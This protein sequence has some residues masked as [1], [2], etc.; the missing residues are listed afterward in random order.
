MAAQALDDFDT[1]GHG[2]AEVPR[3]LHQVA[4]IQV[5]RT[6]TD[7]HQILNQLAWDVDA[8]V[9]ARQE[10]G[11]VPQRDAGATHPVARLGQLLGD[12]VRMI[13]VD[14]EP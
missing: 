6:D 13:D 4:L 2:R 7:A 11:L 14:V 9:D 1:L 10:Y 5:V 3:A 8:V 12:F